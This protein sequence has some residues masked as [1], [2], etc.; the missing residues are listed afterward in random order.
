ML[1]QTEPRLR[2]SNRAYNKSAN[3]FNNFKNKNRKVNFRGGGF[4]QNLKAG[5]SSQWM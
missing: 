2:R 5:V 1:M 4:F 3:L